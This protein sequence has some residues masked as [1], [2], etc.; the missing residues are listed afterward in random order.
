MLIKT[1]FRAKGENTMTTPKILVTGA[2][3]RVGG[4]G[5]L[6]VEALLKQGYPVRA[7]VRT[8]DERAEQLAVQGAE[9]FV[10]DLLD[11]PT[12]QTALHG[13]RRAYFCYPVADSLLQATTTFAV[14]AREV[15]LEAVI[16]LSQLPALAETTSPASRQHWLGERVLDW[17]NIGAIH[18]RPIFF[19]ENLLFFARATILSRGTFSLPY[20]SRATALVAAE[21]VAR[22]AVALLVDPQSHIGKIYPISGSQAL[23]MQEMAAIFSEVLHKAVNYVEIPTEA[24][25]TV[26][27]EQIGLSPYLVAHFSA[28]DRAR[29]ESPSDLLPESQ[30]GRETVRALCGIEPLSLETFIHTHTQAFGGIALEDE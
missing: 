12:V 25:R 26:L 17:A 28:L 11:I 6:V 19:M 20:G 24:W 3:G 29:R 27:S 13:I 5:H 21:D 14:A 1:A 2:A 9:L 10:G 4:T 22:V 30:Q 7:F 16:N 8:H 23:S 18:L 15:G